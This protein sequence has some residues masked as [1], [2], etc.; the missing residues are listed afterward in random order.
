MP[1][2][3]VSILYARMR[4]LDR[5]HHHRF[6]RAIVTHSNYLNLTQITRPNMMGNC[7]ERTEIKHLFF[8]A[9]PGAIHILRHLLDFRCVCSTTPERNYINLSFVTTFSTSQQSS[10]ILIILTFDTMRLIASFCARVSFSVSRQNT[11]VKSF[12]VIKATGF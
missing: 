4:I 6:S 7:R 9:Q 11:R 8:I 2:T 1:F 10:I 3:S 5:L 12:T